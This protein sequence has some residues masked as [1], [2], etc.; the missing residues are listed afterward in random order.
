MYRYPKVRLGIGKSVLECESGS[1]KLSLMLLKISYKFKI[2]EGRTRK[3]NKNNFL[4]CYGGGSMKLPIFQ[5]AFLWP[6]I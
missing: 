6:L 1:I 4:L 2:I 3:K 5:S